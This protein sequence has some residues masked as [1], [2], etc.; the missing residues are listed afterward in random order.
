M[1]KPTK[2]RDRLAPRH[3]STA[4][5]VSYIHSA[6]RD[7][8]VWFAVASSLAGDGWLAESAR[9]WNMRL[10]IPSPSSQWGIS[11]RGLQG[12]RGEGERGPTQFFVLFCRGCVWRRARVSGGSRNAAP[13]LA[14]RVS[15]G[16][17]IGRAGRLGSA[18]L[19]RC[20]F[21]GKGGGAAVCGCSGPSSRETTW[22]RVTL[23]RVE[24]YQN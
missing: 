22:S 5:P 12:L 13:S 21:S 17:E 20:V 7:P 4:S 16:R 11:L 1:Q 23:A 19:C 2:V 15:P 9:V 6:L 8:E 18:F 24:R 10:G 14:A 3:I